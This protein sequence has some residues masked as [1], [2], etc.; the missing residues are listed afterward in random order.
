MMKKNVPGFV[1]KLWTLVDNP[2]TNDVIC[3]S[4]DGT[5]F[6]ILD[7]QRFTK[8]VLPKYFKHSNLSS[9]VRQLNMYGFRKVISIEGGLVKP[10][11]LSVLEFHHMYFQKG[12]EDLLDCIKRKVSSVRTEDTKISQ[13]DMCKV[14]EDVQQVRGKQED[15][16]QKLENMKRENEILWKEVASL[17]KKHSLQQKTVTKVIRFFAS[18]VQG[19][20]VYG[21]KNKRPL[22]IDMSEAP[23]AKVNRQCVLSLNETAPAVKNPLQ[24]EITE[25]PL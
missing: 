3:W 13:E 5:N 19:N 25:T 12:R 4:L 23:P 8:D 17:R 14:L 7:E 18:L 1:S 24:Q 16:D 22:M 21:I 2:G 11:N 6:R 10:K 20:C 9:F 15:M